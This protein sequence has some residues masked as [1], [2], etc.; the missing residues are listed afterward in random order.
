MQLPLVA[1]D[2]FLQVVGVV[3]KYSGQL[4]KQQ[5]H[6]DIKT[7]I[8]YGRGKGESIHLGFYI[9]KWEEN[10]RKKRKSTKTPTTTN[11]RTYN[12]SIILVHKPACVLETTGI[13]CYYFT[14]FQILH[15]GSCGF[16]GL[17]WDLG[18]SFIYLILRQGLTKQLLVGLEADIWTRMV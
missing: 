5:V 10:Q 8:S 17:G 6:K 2:I 7:I 13:V 1:H 18:L 15:L 12:L 16:L 3:F 4:C 11:Q 14:D 9:L